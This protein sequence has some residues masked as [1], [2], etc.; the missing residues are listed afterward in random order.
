[1]CR[2]EDAG[3]AER[4]LRSLLEERLERCSGRSREKE[5][6]RRSMPRSWCGGR[7]GKEEGSCKSWDQTE[8]D[9]ARLGRAEEEG[10]W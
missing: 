4:R 6:A 8:E 3:E 1:M 7:E 2:E 10:S 5:G 9:E